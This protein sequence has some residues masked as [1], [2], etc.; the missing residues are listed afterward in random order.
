[1]P[2]DSPIPRIHISMNP[3]KV[4]AGEFYNI[5]RPPKREFNLEE[6]P[7]DVVFVLN[8]D[9]ELPAQFIDAGRY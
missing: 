3:D 1:M 5:T 7:K 8:G 4:A 2:E 6:L 9:Q